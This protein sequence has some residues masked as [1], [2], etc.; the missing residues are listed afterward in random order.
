VVTVGVQEAVRAERI[1]GQGLREG[2]TEEVT[3]ELGF[4]D[5]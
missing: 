4:K 1:S 2:F 3:F 5:E